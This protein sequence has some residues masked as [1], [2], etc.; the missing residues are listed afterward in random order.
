VAPK[1]SP[2][3]TVSL[4]SKDALMFPFVY[5][6]NPAGWLHLLYFGVVI[7][8]M[9]IKQGRKF[10]DAE[11]PLPD[12]LRHFQRT[13]FTLVMFGVLSVLTARTEW[14]ELFPRALPSWRAILAGVLMYIVAVIFMRPRWRRAVEQRRRVIHL[15]M[16]AN[17]T[18]RVWW[19]VVAVLAG[20]SEEITWRGVQAGLLGNLTRSIVLAALISSIS[21]GAAHMI[22]GW[23]S[24]AVIVGFAHGFHGLVWFANSLYIAMAVHIVYDITAGISY[25]RL[26]RELGYQLDPSPEL[27]ATGQS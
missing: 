23:K 13:T 21:F 1:H 9:A 27:Q 15:F 26:G 4:R 7:P 14:M 12:R 16:P 19:I 17:T 18:E 5:E 2:Y 3:L 20:I 22:Q 11:K 25:G 8:W 24:A 6:I 10:R